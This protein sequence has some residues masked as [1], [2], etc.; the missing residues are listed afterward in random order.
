M[1]HCK[2]CEYF[3]R[4]EKT[5]RI[6]L[7]CEPFS[8]IKEEACLEKMQLLRLDALL[9]LYQ[10]MI[11]FNERLAPVQDKMIKYMERE[12]DDINESEKWKVDD[13]EDDPENDSNPFPY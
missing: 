2:D 13:D 10:R 12:M 9:Q 5:G 7:S 8:T 6:T 1:I 4:D 3:H 11:Q